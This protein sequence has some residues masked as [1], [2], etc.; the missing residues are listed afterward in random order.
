ML[1]MDYKHYLKIALVLL[2]AGLISATPSF[3]ESEEGLDFDDDVGNA[4][5]AELQPVE[6][7]PAEAVSDE[8]APQETEAV[9]VPYDRGERQIPGKKPKSLSFPSY[10]Y[11]SIPDIDSSASDFISVPD[12]WRQFYKGKWYD[13]YNQ[14]VLK[15]DVPIFGSQAHPWFFELSVL[16]DFSTE[17]RKLPIPVGV[18]STDSPTS[19][20]TFGDGNQFVMAETI[21]ASFALIEGNTSFKPQDFEFRFTPVF[22]LNYANVEEDGV[23]RVDPSKGHDR[24]DNFLGINELFADIHL[25]NTSERYDF[26]SSR[27]GIQPFISDFRGFIYNTSEPGVRLFGNYDN[28]IY[29]F[30]LAYFRRMDKD[31]N[32]GL[33]TWFED[34]Y[35]DVYVANLYRQDT[36]AQGH[37]VEFSV[38]HREDSAGNHADDYDNNGFLVRP[39]SIG[40]ER[41]KNIS[42][43][44][45]GLTGDGHFGRINTTEAFYYVT[46]S[47]SHNPIAGRQVDINAAMAALEASYDMNW[48]RFRTSFFWASGDRDPFDGQ[49]EGFDAVIDNPNFAGGDVS[50][51]QRQGIP[52]IGG[53]VVG[54]TNRNSLLPNLRAGK[55]EGQSNFVNPGIRLYNVGVDFE[56]TPK[57]KLI[58]NASYLQFDDVSSLNTLRHDGSFAR[59]LGYDLSTGLLYRPWLNNNVQFRL[60][61][62]TLIVD[63]GFEN[64]FGDDRL[65]Q[66]FS[67]VILQY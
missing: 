53:G 44:Y 63:D 15:A 3:S 13:P 40:D 34:R 43:T 33:N 31:T 6:V 30:N 22:N 23:L 52:F 45:F 46:G 32:S 55:E 12:R 42:S 56:L 36:F 26:I 57:L 41:S 27:T 60:G 38:L 51:F 48:V 50:F 59:G 7:V 39:A 29:Q 4:A 28:N 19:T 17:T 24:T 62:G 11:E 16:S 54:F 66:V 67:N 10:I 20:D 64:L 2:A 58:N 25:V 9:D 37:A 1:V 65:Y 49:A 47:E 14:N 21:A 5:P 18:A 8:S 35:E 61:A